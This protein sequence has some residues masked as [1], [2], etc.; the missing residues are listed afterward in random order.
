[1]KDVSHF[2][3][4]CC[5]WWW[6]CLKK[7]HLKV[8]CSRKFCNVYVL[9]VLTK[10]L[11]QPASVSH[12]FWYCNNETEGGDVTGSSEEKSKGRAGDRHA[13]D[14][15][16]GWEHTDKDRCSVMFRLAAQIW[17][18]AYPD[19]NQIAFIKRGWQG[20]RTSHTVCWCDSNYIS[21]DKN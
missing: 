2:G 12:M 17:F 11:D 21:S 15:K 7:K 19:W 10:L 9:F 5:G 16:G 14:T 20:T 18:L 1:M 8:S 13:V 4:L 3:M 6:I